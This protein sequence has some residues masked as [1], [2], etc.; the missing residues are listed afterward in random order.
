MKSACEWRV[1]LTS[2]TE[3]S[4]NRALKRLLSFNC[5]WSVRRHYGRN[6]LTKQNFQN[7]LCKHSYNQKFYADFKSQ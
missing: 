3:R 5:S 1:V 7:R 6:L 2:E 4:G